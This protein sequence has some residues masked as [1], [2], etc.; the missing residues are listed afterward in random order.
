M[1][2]PIL[3]PDKRGVTASPS[4]KPGKAKRGESEEVLKMKVLVAYHSMSGNTEKLAKA[5]HDEASKNHESYLKKVDEVEAKWLDKH[6]VLFVGS[7]T[8]GGD[9]SAP[10]KKFMTGLP[11]S[12]RLK[13]AAFITHSSPDK[14]DYEKC[15]AAFKA[16][17]KEKGFTL[18]GCC[19]CQARLAPEIQPYVKEARK[20]SDA[21]FAQ[22]MKRIERRPNAADLRNARRFARDMLSKA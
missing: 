22:M 18:L 19:D 3:A 14:A 4:H 5:I 16:S 17:E 1:G 8:H 20:A 2:L 21:E 12:P 6:D 11:R 7:P 15:F 13:V 10:V 9:I